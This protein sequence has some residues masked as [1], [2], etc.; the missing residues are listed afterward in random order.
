[1]KESSTSRKEESS[2][3]SEDNTFDFFKSNISKKAQLAQA[4]KKNAV[5]SAN[6]SQDMSFSNQNK[7]AAL[8]K[9]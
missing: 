4:N 1:M 8:P 3:D 2:S 5:K 7:T 9:T 6:I